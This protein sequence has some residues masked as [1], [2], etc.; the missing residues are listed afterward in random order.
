MPARSAPVYLALEEDVARADAALIVWRLPTGATRLDL[1]TA[2]SYVEMK[3]DVPSEP[4]LLR[5]SAAKRDW[6]CPN[7]T[8]PVPDYL[9]PVILRPADKRLTNLMSDWPWVTSNDLNSL[10]DV[11]ESRVSQMTTR[12][13]GLDMVSKVHIDN[14]HR[15]ALTNRGLGFV[16]RRDR[17]SVA[18][19]RRQWSAESVDPACTLHL[20]KRIVGRRSRH[21]AR[22]MA[23][24]DA[25]HRFLAGLVMQ[26]KRRGYRIVQLDP[27]HRASRYFRHEELLRSIH[28]D[29]F[30]MLRKGSETWPFF[31]EWENRA[32]RPGTMATRLAPY[33]RYYSSKR[34]LDDHGAQPLVLM[35]FGDPLVEA[36]FMWTAKENMGISGVRLPLR[37]SNKAVLE[38]V[39]PLGQGVA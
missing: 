23:H 8:Q 15:F 16:A 18:R 19:L 5:P 39:G 26:A 31:L 11:S 29:A 10:L 35:V 30:G 33:L 34:P 1:H 22:H 2:L 4:P 13:Q 24:T 27:P 38:K 21:L 17:T 25:V 36:R 7:L 37:V 6:Y 3:G 28:P 12:L 20:E 14:H 9:L 32:V